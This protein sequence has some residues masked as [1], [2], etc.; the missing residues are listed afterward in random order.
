MLLVLAA[1]FAAS[2][3]LT[4]IVTPVIA[5]KIAV[6]GITGKDVN[7]AGKPEVPEMGGIA[8]LLGLSSGIIA[9]IFLST[10]LG[11]VAINLPLVLASFLT[12]VLVGL[13][14]VIDDLIGWRKGIR[15]WQHA[16]L[17]IFA[18]LPLMAVNAGTQ[19]IVLPFFGQVQLG[20]LYSLVLIPLAITGASNA[21]NMLAGL[22]GL[23]AGLGILVISTLSF[24]ALLTGKTE[25]LIIGVAATAA[26]LAFLRYNWF[27][28]RIF[29]GDSL[30]LMIGAAVAAI[31][32]TGNMEKVGIAII[33]LH[34]AELAFKAKHK[35]QSECFGIPQKDG[36]LGPDPRGGSLTHAILNIRR[37]TEQRLV[38]AILGMQ[39]VI[40]SIVFIMFRFKLF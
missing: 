35:F 17:P 31:S 16:L 1:V 21:F 2:F 40:C 4:Y 19:H 29:G 6:R 9:A 18:A 30:T 22:N 23:E 5:R 33:A 3:L 20:I 24:I 12:I 28:A 25:A 15:Q 8:P 13:I 14:G 39:A 10:Y 37:L 38:L 11:S 26:L 27:P 32:I 7:K 34:W 36:T